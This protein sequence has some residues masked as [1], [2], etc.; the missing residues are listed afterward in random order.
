VVFPSKFSLPRPE[1]PKLPP[2]DISYTFAGPFEDIYATLIVRLFY[3]RAFNLGQLWKN[4]A[5][6]RD[7]LDHVCGLQLDGIEEGRGMISVFYDA[8]ASAES[9]LLFLK[10]VQEH[11]PLVC[12][13]LLAFGIRTAIIP[14]PLDR[15]LGAN[16]PGGDGGKG[17][18]AQTAVRVAHRTVCLFELQSRA[19]ISAA[20]MLQMGLEE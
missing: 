18:G 20:A 3:G 17:S 15:A 6:F 19:H 9:K 11:R 10:F 2:A 16:G 1:V 4:A 13:R 7:P 12:H 8:A 5:E 14:P